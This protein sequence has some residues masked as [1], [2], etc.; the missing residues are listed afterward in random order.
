MKLLR[1]T[2]F[3]AAAL[4]CSTQAY[5]VMYLARPY[6]PNMARWLTR[7]PIGERGFQVL[8]LASGAGQTLAPD[9]SRDSE[10]LAGP[11]VYAFNGNDA[12]NRIDPD[13]LCDLEF[14]SEGRSFRDP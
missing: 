6:E 12:V 5:A 4:I 2:F 13:G 7:D 14:V 9:Q 1:I 10:A 11:N 8:Q 3:A